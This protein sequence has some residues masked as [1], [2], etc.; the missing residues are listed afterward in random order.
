MTVW[1]LVSSAAMAARAAT[2]LP[3]P[4]S[5]VTTPRACSSMHQAMRAVGLGVGT[6]GVEHGGGEVLAE[7]HAG[8]APVGAEAVDAHGPTSSAPP[9]V[10]VVGAGGVG[11]GQRQL[12]V[13]DGIGPGRL[14][15]GGR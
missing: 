1:R 6:V 11:F 15:G 13:V 12:G 7:G 9:V 14:H 10:V 4:T 5:P 8:Q 3:A 2:V